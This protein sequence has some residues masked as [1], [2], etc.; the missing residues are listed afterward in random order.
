MTRVSPAGQRRSAHDRAAA[1]PGQCLRTYLRERGLVR[2]Q[3]GLRHRRLRRLHRAR[4]RRAGAQLRLPGVPRAEGRE[5]TTVEGLA[6]AG[7]LHPVQQRFLDAQGFQC[8]F[9]TAGLIMTTAA[10]LDRRR[11]CDDLPRALKGNLC[12]CTGLPR[13]RRRGRAAC[14]TSTEPPP[15]AAVGA[16][17]GAPAGPAGGHRHRAATRSTSTCPGVLH[18]KV[19]RSPHAHARIV[20]I[21]TAAALAV[22]GRARRCSPTRTPRTGSSPPPGTSTPTEDPADT[23]VLDDVVRFVGQR[24]AAVVADTEAAA[25]E[26]CRR[27]RA[28]TYEV[29]PAVLDP[30]AAMRPARPLVHGDKGPTPGS[31]APRQRGRRAARPSSATSRPASPRPT[32]CT[33]RPSAPPGCS[34]P[35][36]RRTARSAGS[37]TTAG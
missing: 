32:S 1:A 4:R 16:S 29:L 37:T 14:A 20:A 7:R 24:V 19:L 36:W 5:V 34:T 12:R 13:D 6:G 31:P 25:E 35:A 23:R 15:G 10:A 26:G 17:L 2:G 33:R 21:D 8:G 27:A 30:E 28:S 18:L 22:A 3:E 9:C 11:S